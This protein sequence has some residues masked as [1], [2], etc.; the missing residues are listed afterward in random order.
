MIHQHWMTNMNIAKFDPNKDPLCARCTTMEEMF[1][2][3]F[4]CKSSHAIQTHQKAMTIFKA[5]LRKCD[6]APIVQRAMI[7][8]IEK[9][10]RG[11]ENLAFKDLIIS[12]YGMVW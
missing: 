6:T 2:Y 4:A 1:K 9:H 10:R 11:Y 12:W 8:C 7:Q 3:I 5:D